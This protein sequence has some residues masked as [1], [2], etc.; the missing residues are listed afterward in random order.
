MA[1]VAERPPSRPMVTKTAKVCIVKGMAKGMEIHEQ[2]AIR[3][4]HAAIPVSFLVFICMVQRS[5]YLI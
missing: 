5:F 3:A 2:T 1:T 4:T